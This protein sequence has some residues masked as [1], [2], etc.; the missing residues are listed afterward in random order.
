MSIAFIACVESGNLENQALLLFRSIRKYAGRFKESPIYSFQPRNG[1][2]LNKNTIKAFE[3]L[4]VEHNTELLNTHY[5]HYPIGNKIFASARAE[6]IKKEDILVFLDT[7]TVIL[8]E[9]ADFDIPA[10]IAVAVRPVDSKNNGSTGPED[11]NDSYW[12]RLYSICGVPEGQYV[13]TTIDNRRIRA[14]WNSGLIAVRRS[15]CLFQQWKDNFIKLMK[16]GHIPKERITRKE[17]LTFM[18]QLAL[19]PTLTNVSER[20]KIL[21]YRYNYPLP[22]RPLMVKPYRDTALEDLIH[23]HYHRWFNKPDFLS[24]LRPKLNTGSEVFKWISGFLPFEPII[25]KPMRF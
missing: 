6:E 5:D 23:V 20:L 25:D 2:P 4:C 19:A 15:E 1:P 24:L 7:D 18:D 3:E 13:T 14:F 8:N 16:A 21:N 10:D 22:K 12:Q 11:S 17:R 9:P